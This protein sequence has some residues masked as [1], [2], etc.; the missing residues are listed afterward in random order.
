MIWNSFKPVLNDKRPSTWHEDPLNV[1]VVGPTDPVVT[2]VG[3]A[4]S[5]DVGDNS[6]DALLVPLVSPHAAKNNNTTM[7]EPTNL[8]GLPIT[9]ASL[10]GY[11]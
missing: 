8:I 2:V 5:V 6:S 3:V 10:V 9:V 1:T 4:T 7:A 11:Q